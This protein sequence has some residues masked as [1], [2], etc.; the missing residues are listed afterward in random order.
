V[1]R[2]GCGCD[3]R[4]VSPKV[5]TRR[6]QRQ[7]LDPRTRAQRGGASGSRSS[8]DGPAGCSDIRRRRHSFITWAL[9][10]GTPTA[11]VSK[12]CE[13]SVR[14]LEATYAH[15]IPQIDG[16]DFLDQPKADTQLCIVISSSVLHTTDIRYSDNYASD[17]AYSPRF[18]TI[19][20]FLASGYADLDRS[21]H[22]GPIRERT[23][24]LGALGALGESGLCEIL[25]RWVRRLRMH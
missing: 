2:R 10:A 1:R 14:V 3:Q 23:S 20:S 19:S 22:C 4:R 18:G 16:V 7:R 15:V 24:A 25:R 11:I 8:R 5:P 12:W 17:E 9:E 13:V 21:R 6:K